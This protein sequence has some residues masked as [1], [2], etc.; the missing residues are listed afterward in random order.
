MAAKQ[1]SYSGIADLG[2]NLMQ[3][4]F[5]SSAQ[6]AALNTANNTKRIA[7][8]MDALVARMGGG[9]AQEKKM[10]GVR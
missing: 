6:E 10:A 2:K 4:A 7:D 3:A 9:P 5:G 8:K 1:A